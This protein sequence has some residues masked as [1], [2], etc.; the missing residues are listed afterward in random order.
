MFAYLRQREKTRLAQY[1]SPPRPSLEKRLEARP[2]PE[3]S[4]LQQH[5]YEGANEYESNG[6]GAGED[7]ISFGEED[8][9][10]K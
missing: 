10:D 7:C 3:D 2:H 8:W 1:Q 4:N 9:W 6:N 5:R